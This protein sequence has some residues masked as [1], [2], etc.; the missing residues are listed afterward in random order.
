MKYL[1][2]ILP[3][4]VYFWA[5]CNVDIIPK[6]KIKK[7][8]ATAI[9]WYTLKKS[10]IIDTSVKNLILFTLWN[11]FCSTQEKRMPN[12]SMDLVVMLVLGKN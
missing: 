8:L 7:S 12:N 5:K 4:N 10:T 2:L 1:Y 6:Q 11:D 9:P 3:V